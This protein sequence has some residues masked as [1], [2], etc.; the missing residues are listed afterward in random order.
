MHRVERPEQI[1]ELGGHP[2]G[3]VSKNAQE[4][5]LSQSSLLKTSFAGSA[6]APKQEAATRAT[7][8]QTGLK[9]HDEYCLVSEADHLALGGSIQAQINRMMYQ[10]HKANFHLVENKEEFNNTNNNIFM[11]SMRRQQEMLAQRTKHVR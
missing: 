11:D 3:L 8:D 10:T 5:T 4:K 6:T 2:V 9:G 1:Y 7:I